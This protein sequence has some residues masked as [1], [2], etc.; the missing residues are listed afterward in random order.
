MVSLQRL[1]CAVV[2]F[3]V[4]LQPL[5]FAVEGFDTHGRYGSFMIPR[6]PPLF[7]LEVFLHI[8][9]LCRLS[10]AF[11]KLQTRTTY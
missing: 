3:P 5:L 1:L 10:N 8:V 7:A 6:Q 4:S 2:V 11:T 9:D